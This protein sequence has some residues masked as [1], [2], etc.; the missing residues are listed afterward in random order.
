MRRVL[1]GVITVATLSVGAFSMPAG[2]SGGFRVVSVSSTSTSSAPVVTAGPTCDPAGRCLAGYT[3]T[4]D[5]SGA[6]QGTLVNDGTS[7]LEAGFSTFHVAIIGLFAGSVEGCGEG[8]MALSYPLTLG[9]SAPFSGQLEVIAGSGTGAFDGASGTGTYTFDQSTGSS[10][11]F[12]RL[13]C[14]AA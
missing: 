3:L 4:A 2:A 8:T 7:W 11:T 9:G 6:M 1:F 10:Q 5:L 14:R 13:R 12:L